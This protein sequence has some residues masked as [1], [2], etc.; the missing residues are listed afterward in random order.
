MV[1]SRLTCRLPAGAVMSGPLPG[2]AGPLPAWR[3]AA[4]VSP[5]ASALD[6]A[7]AAGL[8]D[9]DVK[10]ANMLADTRP[11]RPDDVYLSDFGL[12][13]GALSSVRLTGSGLF[14]GTLDY[15][16]A[17]QIAAL[18]WTGGLIST[19]SRALHSSC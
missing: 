12:S 6:A 1:K 15:I 10:P 16:A 18:Q 19:P 4:F 17:E 14:L 2:R 9:R 7:H 5:A 8:V 13:K 3:A 11:G